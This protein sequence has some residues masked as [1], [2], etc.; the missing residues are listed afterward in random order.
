MSVSSCVCLCVRVCMHACSC[1]R[2]VER[3][4]VAAEGQWGDLGP[5][6]RPCQRETERMQA[7]SLRRMC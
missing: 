5:N 2:V 7:S 3:G 6:N 4:R 1:V